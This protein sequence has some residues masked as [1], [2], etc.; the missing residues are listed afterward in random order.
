M[1]EGCRRDIVVHAD[2]PLKL[3]IKL[4]H[5]RF[6]LD[7]VERILKL[8]IV[9]R[10][11]SSLLFAGKVGGFPVVLLHHGRAGGHGLGGA[12]TAHPADD[13]VV[14]SPHDVAAS[15]PLPFAGAVGAVEMFH[16]NIL[17]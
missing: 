11:I 16:A 15:V 9:V 8:E 2:L 7:D 10:V 6:L 17:V 5:N 13:L 14:G 1:H 4:R 12:E 3:G